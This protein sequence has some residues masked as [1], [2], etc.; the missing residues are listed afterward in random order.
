MA[1]VLFPLKTYKDFSQLEY[2]KAD[3]KNV[4]VYGVI[5]IKDGKQYIGYSLNLYERLTVHI[6]G[7]SL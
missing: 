1:S 5:N 6:K 3:L 4:G 7:V 2:L